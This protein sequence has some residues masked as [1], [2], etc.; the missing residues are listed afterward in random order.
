VIVFIIHKIYTVVQCVNIVTN[1]SIRYTLQGNSYK[2]HY[3]SF[4]KYINVFENIF[5]VI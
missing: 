1:K 3:K 5:Y 4:G 2:G